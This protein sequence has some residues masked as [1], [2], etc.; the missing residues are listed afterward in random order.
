[1]YDRL[2]VIICTLTLTLWS[3]MSSANLQYIVTAREYL[4][5]RDKEFPLDDTKIDNM[6]NLLMRINIL[7]SAWKKPIHIN[8]GYRPGRYN[9]EV[10]GVANSAHLSCEAIDI[11]D[12]DGTM[13][14]WLVTNQKHMLE[15]LGLYLERRD[16]TPRWIHLTS[17]RP[18]SG[19]HIFIP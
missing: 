1:M 14:K 13:Y 7:A 19:L 17:R 4:K 8:S 12:E 10:G 16:Y 3:T 11:A 6:T 5:E 18:R 2:L 9:L 15:E